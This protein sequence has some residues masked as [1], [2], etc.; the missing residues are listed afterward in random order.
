MFFQFWALS[1][2]VKQ[3]RAAPSTQK[4]RE[5]AGEQRY[6]VSNRS[7]TG[8]KNKEK[9]PRLILMDKSRG[10]HAAKKVKFD[11]GRNSSRL[12]AYHGDMCLRGGV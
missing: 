10:I 6:Q 12:C 1:P 7:L 3:L 4:I 9:G 8:E 2:G 5:K 11:E